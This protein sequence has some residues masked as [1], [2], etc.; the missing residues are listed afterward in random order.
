MA[1]IMPG[2]KIITS[3]ESV[4]IVRL[5]FSVLPTKLILG[6]LYVFSDILYRPKKVHFSYDALFGLAIMHFIVNNSFGK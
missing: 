2:A 3:F 5:W 4:K 6:G 1:F